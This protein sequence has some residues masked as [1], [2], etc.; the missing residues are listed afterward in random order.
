MS[1]EKLKEIKKR[2]FCEEGKDID[3]YLKG[4]LCEAEDEIENIPTP[5]D[6]DYEVNTPKDEKEE[7]DD[8]YEGFL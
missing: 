4:T 1:K 6:A 2:N 5:E 8:R 3:E 7:D